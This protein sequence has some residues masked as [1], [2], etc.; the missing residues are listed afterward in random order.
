MGRK[1]D[2][3]RKELEVNSFKGKQW[4]ETSSSRRFSL[5]LLSENRELEKRSVRAASE[6][7]AEGLVMGTDGAHV[8]NVV[9]LLI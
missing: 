5:F 6:E 8:L 3:P 4:E 9:I 7:S 2:R 1:A